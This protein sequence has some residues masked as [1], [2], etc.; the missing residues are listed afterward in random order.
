MG[1]LLEG[2]GV[3]IISYTVSSMQSCSSFGSDNKYARRKFLLFPSLFCSI[4]ACIYSRNS[5]S[6]SQRGSGLS[7][8]GLLSVLL[9]QVK[10]FFSPITCIMSNFD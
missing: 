8:S 1:R 3:G 6:K 10:K 5:A 7:E 9:Y 2:F 4:G